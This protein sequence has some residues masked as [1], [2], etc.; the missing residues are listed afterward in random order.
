VTP[1][2]GNGK[3]YLAPTVAGGGD[4]EIGNYRKK[5]ESTEK[6]KRWE[7]SKLLPFS[8]KM[9]SPVKHCLQ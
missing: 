3:I 4:R 2:S 6:G 8:L 9:F 5:K 1:K 7:K